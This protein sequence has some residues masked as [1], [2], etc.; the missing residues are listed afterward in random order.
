[1]N[2][3][4]KYWDS[5]YVYVLLLVPGFCMC[6]G[7]FWTICKW[8]GLYPDLPW[9]EIIAFD[10]SQ[11]IYLAVALYFI[12]R[13]KKDSSY[14]S[15]HLSYIKGYIVL[16]L[17]IQYNF[18][19]YLF[20]S[21][22]VWEC[23][24]LF[25]GVIVFL[26][27]SKLMLINVLVYFLSLVAAHMISPEKFL[28]LE[29]PN[30]KEI[31]AFRIVIFILTSCCIVIIVY[32]VER[33]LMQAQESSEENVHLMEKQ[34]E[35]Y[36]D[37]EF[38]DTELRKFRHDIKNHFICM[39][40]LSESG[41]M[42]KLQ[43]YFVDLQQSFSF[44]KNIHFSGNDIVDA[45][46]HSDLSRHCS[47]NVNVAVYG[48]LP[49][50]VTVSSMD[51]CTLFSNLLSNAVAAA[52]QCADRQESRLAVRFSGGSTYFSIEVA[53]SISA[54]NE[55]RKKDRNHG[56]GIRKIENVVEKYGGRFEKK[57]EQEMLSITVYLP[58]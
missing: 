44:Q 13:N 52:N 31:I 7:L 50:I 23:T 30:V 5:V 1:M 26:F 42:E 41:K 21:V 16:A 40:A 15:G 19:L 14:I 57:S 29:T 11:V 27:D 38:L 18:I 10:L 6:A 35:Y 36:K 3:I 32:F 12:R 34:L 58:I 8:L 2:V 28:P 43:E 37:M 24:F 33:F 46:L 22:H 39:E 17:F 49:E 20:A 4:K 48:S 53:N 51:L 56:F 54:E 25:F 45:I 9:I 47:E 55:G